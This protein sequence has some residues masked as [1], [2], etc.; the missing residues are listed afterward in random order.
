[1]FRI[2]HTMNRT[3]AWN[4]AFDEMLIQRVDAGLS[5]PCVRFYTWTPWCVTLGSFQ[6]ADEQ[7]QVERLQEAGYEV[8]KRTTGGRAVFHAQE[9]T[10]TICARKD[11]APWGKTLG[12]TYDWIAER[13]LEGLAQVGFQGSLERGDNA[14]KEIARDQHLTKPPCFSSASRAEIAWQGRKV[15]GSAQRRTRNA[16][17]QHGSILL[18]PAHAEL[19]DF[20]DFPEEQKSMLRAH[21]L[22]HSVSLS[23]IPGVDAKLPNVLNA[24]EHT[25]AQALGAAEGE[26][27]PEE[28]AATKA[29]LQPKARS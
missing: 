28:L 8:A 23:E 2:L 14:A 16:F 6:A 19:V 22:Q 29:L 15:V 3:G 25:F 4:M 10:Y 7:L 27:A 1:M 21:L 24:L 20:L 9:L 11:I 18:G 12:S 17:L 5:E 26:I 13:L